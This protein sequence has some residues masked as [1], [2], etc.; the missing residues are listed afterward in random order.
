M[1]KNLDFFCHSFENAAD[2][3][4]KKS[5]RKRL[6]TKVGFLKIIKAES[7]SKTGLVI[8]IPLKV[9]K[10]LDFLLLRRKKKYLDLEILAR[11]HIPIE[12]QRAHIIFIKSKHRRTKLVAQEKDFLN[13][14]TIK[15]STKHPSRY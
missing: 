4:E 11:E 3:A 13:K 14:I 9:V 8:L 12:E 1:F 6:R 10:N 7:Q 2:G 15:G 5:Q